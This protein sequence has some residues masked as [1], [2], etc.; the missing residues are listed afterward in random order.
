M[1]WIALLFVAAMATGCSPS[2]TPVI[3][4]PTPIEKTRDTAR[5]QAE[6]IKQKREEIDKQMED[7]QSP[8]P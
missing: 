6:L 8:K 2:E 3:A 1:K 5:E 4:S 7:V